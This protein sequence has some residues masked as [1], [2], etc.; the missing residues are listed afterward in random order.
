VIEWFFQVNDLVRVAH[1][2]YSPD[3]AP[4]DSL[5]FSYTKRFLA[6]CKSEKLDELFRATIA[7]E[8]EILQV[9]L[10]EILGEWVTSVKLDTE[11]NGNCAQS[12]SQQRNQFLLFV[13]AWL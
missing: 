2:P 12:Q 5:L 9:Q 11:T 4:L 1:R 13:F 7:L 10:K 3:S 8:E 6:G